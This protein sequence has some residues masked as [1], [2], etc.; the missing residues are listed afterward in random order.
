MMKKDIDFWLGIAA[1]S[2][3]IGLGIVCFLGVGGAISELA[4]WWLFGIGLVAG[5]VMGL[6]SLLRSVN[7]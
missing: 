1:N 6:I 7:Q 3:W 5:G 4:T 2:I